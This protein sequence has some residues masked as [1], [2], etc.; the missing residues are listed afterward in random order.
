MQNC[1][2]PAAQIPRCTTAANDR[3][4][5][6]EIEEII[7]REPY[8]DVEHQSRRSYIFA[9]RPREKSMKMPPSQAMRLFA[10]SDVIA[11][12]NLWKRF[13]MLRRSLPSAV[14]DLVFR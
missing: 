5:G 2:S 1:T 7:E 10:E 4:A 14:A 12:L 9:R 11:S 8:P 3:P 6:F 13:S